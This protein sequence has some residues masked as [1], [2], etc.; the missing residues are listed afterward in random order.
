MSVVGYIPYQRSSA[1]AEAGWLA[2][3]FGCQV[4]VAQNA[5]TL[6]LARCEQL[7]DPD[8]VRAAAES[9]LPLRWVIAEGPGGF[10]WSAVLRAN[11][12][13]GGVTVLPYLNPR[14][15][16]DVACVAGYLAFAAPQDRIFLGS[17][18]S[19]R[20]YRA[21]GV[22]VNVGE[23]YGVDCD[24][25]RLRPRAASVLDELG[26]P[27]GRI[28]LFAGRAQPD[29]N[30]YRFLRVALRVRFL[31]SDLSVVIASHVVDESY[32]SE[33]RHQLGRDQGVYFVINPTRD[34]LA[35]LYNVADVFATA[36]TSHFETFGRAP[37]E[38]LVCGTPAIAPC[39][40][41]FAEVLAQP[42]GTVVDVE[43]VEGIPEVNEERMLRAIYDVL[44][45]PSTIP[46]EEIAAAGRAHFCRS[47]TIRLL[48]HVVSPRS[49]HAKPDQLAP[50]DLSLPLTWTCELHEMAHLPPMDALTRLWNL[51][52]SRDLERH[53]DQ[54]RETVRFSLCRLAREV[55]E[56]Q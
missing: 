49:G 2:S 55:S 13:T 4:L 25:F 6:N 20:I 32:L 46:A 30:L 11:G 28:L 5:P 54:L 21:L 23:P 42:G 45:S 22:D 34:Q 26:I 29:K 41:G 24:V 3:A 18:P 27:R 33:A 17:T 19:A 48:E 8:T 12:Y 43:M 10:L 14:C 39:Y 9:L 36:A 31:F 38:A 16:Y 50:A 1:S 53:D 56:T 7:P 44:S 37:A 52:V 35:D 51:P 40:D 47:Q 15:W